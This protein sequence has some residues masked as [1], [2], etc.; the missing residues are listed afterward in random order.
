[1]HSR[2]GLSDIVTNVL[3]I[4]LVLVAVGIIWAFVRPTINQGAS[5]LEGVTTVY[6]TMLSLDPRSATIDTTNEVVSFIVRRNEGEGTLVGFNVILANNAGASRLFRQNVTLE[7]LESRRVSIDYTGWGLGQPARVSVAPIFGSSSGQERIGSVSDPLGFSGNTTTTNV[8][9]AV[10]GN[11]IV[12]SPEVCDGGSQACTTVSGYAG[13]RACLSDCSGY[14]SCTTAL[15]CGDSIRSNPE[16]CDPPQ[17]VCAPAYGGSCTYCNG[18]CTNA[19]VQGG[20][21]G[22]GTCQTQNEDSE[23]C[24]QD[25]SVAPACNLDNTP[26]TLCNCNSICEPGAGE[27]IS[28]GDCPP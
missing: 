27:T 23:S 18:S 24:W 16:Q 11:G 20:F 13:S 25:C 15:F 28:C 8:T 6:G 12:Q 2:K 10:C 1:M 5:Q 21:C 22:D 7:P 26:P 3:I 17:A 19:T 9:T 4:L 14:G